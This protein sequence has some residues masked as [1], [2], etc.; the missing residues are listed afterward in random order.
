MR[1]SCCILMALCHL[2][3]AQWLGQTLDGPHNNYGYALPKVT[4]TSSPD[5][6]NG[7]SPKPTEVP[8]VDDGS[9]IELV[10]LMRRSEYW[11]K[12]KRQTTSW[13]NAKTCG[14][15]D[16]DASEPFV[17]GTSMTCS[18]N[19]D[20]VV[21]C[22]SSDDTGPFFTVCLDYQAVRSGLCN[23]SSVGPQ[24][25]CCASSTLP[26]CIMYLWPGPKPKSMYLCHTKQGVQTMLDVPRSILDAST[27]STLTTASATSSAPTDTGTDTPI[28]AT[29]NDPVNAGAI[30]GGVV[31]GV[32]CLALV[33]GAIAFF[34][35][36]RRNNKSNPSPNNTP[37]TI[38]VYTAVPP[39]DNLLPIPGATQ[40]YPSPQLPQNQPGF[41]SPPGSSTLRSKTPY[42]ANLSPPNDSRYS[43]QYDPSKPPPK[44]Q[45]GYMYG[46]QQ[47]QGSTPP[48]PQGQFLSELD[49]DGVVRGQTG[50]PAEMPADGSPSW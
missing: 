49:S 48:P 40:P 8:F 2:V 44:M 17:C 28:P 38:P 43:Y 6:V 9:E 14:W 4:A 50:N 30:A 21:G 19:V 32:A 16:S 47:L 45:Q 13:L 26:A 10:E 23:P 1:A 11:L 27:R 12:A 20:N 5:G 46:P 24:T 34:L 42:L 39:H 36:R 25:G 22:L 41:L 31:G 18:T 3:F 33:A 35:I 29:G 7:W 15:F 37:S